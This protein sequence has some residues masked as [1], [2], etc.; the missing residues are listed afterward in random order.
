MNGAHLEVEASLTALDPE[1]DFW[2]D[3]EEMIEMKLEIVK[4]STCVEAHRG[5]AWLKFFQ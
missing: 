3:E 1:V 5:R 2:I 4:A